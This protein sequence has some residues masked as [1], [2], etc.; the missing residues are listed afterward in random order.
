MR[1]CPSGETSTPLTIPRSVIGLWISGSSTVA[2]AARTACSRAVGLS[3]VDVRGT[4]RPSIDVA[5]LLDAACAPFGVHCTSGPGT[6]VLL[7]VRLRTIV[8]RD[9]HRGHHRPQRGTTAVG[10]DPRPARRVAGVPAGPRLDH[11]GPG[12]RVGGGAGPPAGLLRRA[13]AAGRGP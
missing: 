11:P 2:S 5:T 10:P 1:A 3:V 9:G 7:S 13:R 12:G 8:D 6:A 4:A